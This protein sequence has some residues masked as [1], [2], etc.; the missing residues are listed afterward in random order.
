[1]LSRRTNAFRW[2]TLVAAALAV[3]Q[4]EGRLGF[5]GVVGQGV[6][7]G[8]N[9]AVGEHD[10]EGYRSRDGEANHKRY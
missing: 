5:A 4:D 6:K 7:Q 10:A 1:M 2:T 3:D 8:Q 9:A